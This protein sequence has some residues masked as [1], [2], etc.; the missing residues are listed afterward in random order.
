MELLAFDD[1]V[2]TRA[3]EL[4]PPTLRSIDAIHLASALS[5]GRELDVLVT[6]DRRL[7]TAAEEARVAVAS[8]A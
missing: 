7:A 1:E 3:G 2:I 5:F 4:N 8:P 6:Y